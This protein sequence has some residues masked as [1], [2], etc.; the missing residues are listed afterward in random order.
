M[1]TAVVS[2]SQ[3]PSLVKYMLSN[4]LNP[5][6]PPSP[7]AGLHGRPSYPPQSPSASYPPPSPSGMMTMHPQGA[8]GS[9]PPYGMMPQGAPVMSGP[10][11]SRPGSQGNRPLLAPLPITATAGM[12][13]GQGAYPAM[14]SPSSNPMVQQQQQPQVMSLSGPGSLGSSSKP[15]SGGIIVADPSKM[16]MLLGLGGPQQPMGPGQ[17]QQFMA[18]SGAYAPP[19][20]QP[21]PAPIPR[22]LPVKP[23]T[24]TGRK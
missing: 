15:A 24:S 4:A 5:Q 20:P 22:P 13:Q 1:E 16:A 21:S 17:Q 11:H 18:M 19:N 9:T 2:G 23:N 3:S 14:M 7:G 6:A 10:S 12:M 8:Y